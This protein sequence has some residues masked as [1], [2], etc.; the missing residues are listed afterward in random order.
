MRIGVL[1]RT[2]F[3]GS[4]TLHLLQ[5]LISHIVQKDAGKN[6]S[7]SHV[8]DPGLLDKNSS[9]QTMASLW[10]WCFLIASMFR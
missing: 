6:T 10:G 7:L 9:I 8:I 3:R 1:K 2:A 5:Y 4:E